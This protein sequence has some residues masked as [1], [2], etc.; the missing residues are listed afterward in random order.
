MALTIFSNIVADPTAQFPEA[1]NLNTTNNGVTATSLGSNAKAILFNAKTTTATYN[2][3]QFLVNGVTTT[4]TVANEYNGETF[5]LLLNSG[6]S[7][8]YTINTASALQKLSAYNDFDSISTEKTR[9][10][11]LN[12]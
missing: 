1:I 11:N 9:L 10:W 2:N 7:F 8:T 6:D 5:A 3:L 12:G 4:F